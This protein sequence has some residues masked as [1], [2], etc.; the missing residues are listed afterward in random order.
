MDSIRINK[1]LAEKGYTT[2]RGADELIRAGR[3]LIN[4]RVAV[5]G[6]KVGPSDAV[7]VAA[8]AT[9]SQER[10]RVYYAYNKPVGIV[11]HGAQDD[12]KDIAD[13]VPIAGV[14][15]VGRLDKDSHGILLLTND[16]RITERLLSPTFDHEKEYRVRVKK[17]LKQSILTRLAKGVKLED[18]YITKP[19][20]TFWDSEYVFRIVLTEGKKHQIRRMVTACGYEVADLERIRIMNVMLGSLA[21]GATRPLTVSERKALLKSLGL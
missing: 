11:T 15:P 9:E 5:L 12:D 4:G 21:S 8:K 13:V 19:A 18:G 10:S 20:E 17:Q 7:V 3:V 2:R 16:G 6:D 14:F 1:Y